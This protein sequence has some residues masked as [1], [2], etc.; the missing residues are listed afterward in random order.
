MRP[1]QFPQREEFAKKRP[2]RIEVQD[3]YGIYRQI[4]EQKSGLLDKA[5]RI[6]YQ[7]ES[8][9]P[10]TSTQGSEDHLFGEFNL[11][12]LDSQEGLFSSMGMRIHVTH[13]AD[14]FQPWFFASYQNPLQDGGW[15]P[16]EVTNLQSLL[17]ATDSPLVKHVAVDKFHWIVLDDPYQQIRTLVRLGFEKA[18]QQAT[19]HKEG[20]RTQLKREELWVPNNEK[21]RFVLKSLRILTPD[22]L[23][24]LAI[25]QYHILED[26]PINVDFIAWLEEKLKIERPSILL[27]DQDAFARKLQGFAKIVEKVVN[28]SAQVKNTQQTNVLAIAPDPG[29]DKA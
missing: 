13:L 18:E 11:G 1:D 24:W 23:P 27:G 4:Q 7:E 9:T 5:R 26:L 25:T 14:R 2:F 10:T 21:E 19:A 12:K 3:P 16:E 6:F 8:Y 28:A 29:P 20:V 17:T 15:I 22:P